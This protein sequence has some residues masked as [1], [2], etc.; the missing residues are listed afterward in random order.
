MAGM[1]DGLF[2][3]SRSFVDPTQMEEERRLCYVGMT[4]AKRRLYLTYARARKLYGG[5]QMNPP[6]AFINDIEP[7]HKNYLNRDVS[8]DGI[9]YVEEGDEGEG[10]LDRI[11]RG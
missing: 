7:A 11:M 6:S 2:P 3:H 5:L 10:I 4:R 1:E 8:E 9:E